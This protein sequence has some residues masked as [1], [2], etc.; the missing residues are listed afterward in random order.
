MVNLFISISLLLQISAVRIWLQC[1]FVMAVVLTPILKTSVTEKQHNSCSRVTFNLPDE[2]SIIDYL[3]EENIPYAAKLNSIVR[4][5]TA[6]D[7]EDTVLLKWIK[8]FKDNILFL[9]NNERIIYALLNLNWQTKDD[10][11]I[12]IYQD[13]ILNLVTAHPAFIRPVLSMIFNIFTTVYDS[14]DVITELEEKHYQNGHMLLRNIIKLVPLCE[15]PLCVMLT[16][17]F[18][19]MSRP[20]KMLCCYVHNLLQLCSY[21]PSKRSTVLECIIEKLI[22][23]DVHCSKD[24][25]EI[26]EQEREDNET[27]LMVE[28]LN[29][30]KINRTDTMAYPLAQ[31]LDSI[32]DLMFK[33][34]QDTCFP[35][36]GKDLDWEATKK[37]YKELLT[38]FDKI[39]LPTHGCCYVQYLMFHICSF[40][41]ELSEGFLDYL[42]KK[43]QN[44]SLGSFYRQIA[45][46]YIGSFLARAKYITVHTV[47]ACLELLCKWIHSYIDN[48]TAQDLNV[49]GTFHSV[50]QT[51]FYVFAFRSQELIEIDK[52]F[53]LLRSLNFDRIVTC[54][55]NPLGYCDRNIV[56]NF[57][58]IA[59][60]FQ[61]VYVYPVIEKNNRNLLY[62]NR[63]TNPVYIAG[64]VIQ[65]FFPFDPYLLKK[66]KHWIESNYRIYNHCH[67]DEDI[68][69]T[70]DEDKDETNIN[71]SFFTYSTS[72]GFKKSYL[73]KR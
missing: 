9:E 49:H 68:M 66:S 37:L 19:F 34:V 53:R 46:F 62:I 13:L 59:R 55:L 43:V 38:V 51:V 14:N 45:A 20:T 2:N 39:I 7:T 6:A 36:G 47:T 30:E 70:T 67:K 57:A 27:H 50:C 11:F 21:F 63:M 17:K 52:G 56:Q 3:K 58:N 4:R 5:L 69:D 42:W 41:Q 48:H 12:S 33:Y 8:D 15:Y 10:K 16:V 18:P 64:A 22:H 60:N 61:I 32:I 26:Y 72:P 23:I 24:T 71:D 73:T 65:T 1:D 28:D 40:K 29:N 25:I 54:R 44:P 31:T 35:D